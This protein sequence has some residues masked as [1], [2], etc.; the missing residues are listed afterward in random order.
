MKLES[1]VTVTE[2][3]SM[4]ECCWKSE[5]STTSLAGYKL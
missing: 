2:L 4:D 5:V 1:L 3:T